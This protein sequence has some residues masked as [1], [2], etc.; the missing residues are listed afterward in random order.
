MG[1]AGGTTRTQCL[2]VYKSLVVVLV[3]SFTAAQPL[4]VTY[5][6][7]DGGN[8][9]IEEPEHNSSE[10]V[11]ESACVCLEQGWGFHVSHE[12][13]FT[14]IPQGAE[15]RT[16]T[17]LPCLVAWGGVAAPSAVDDVLDCSALLLGWMPFCVGAASLL[18]HKQGTLSKRSLLAG[19]SK[20]CRRSASAVQSTST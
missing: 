19:K 2:F 5:L 11:T 16:L 13:R 8:H 15:E 14:T 1:K 17:S 3:V 7:L 4:T 12:S 18:L 20:S 9:S 10:C 6:Q